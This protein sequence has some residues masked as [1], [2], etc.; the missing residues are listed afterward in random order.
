MARRAQIGTFLPLPDT[1]TAPDVLVL[2]IA[3]VVDRLTHEVTAE[4]EEARHFDYLFFQH[5]HEY[6][7]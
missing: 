4:M 6:D 1:P 5:H 7:A 3:L 2:I